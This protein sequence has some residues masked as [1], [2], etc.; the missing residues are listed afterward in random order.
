LEAVAADHRRRRYQLP[1]YRKGR[2]AL[3]GAPRVAALIEE[4]ELASSKGETE[5]AKAGKQPGAAGLGHHGSHIT[6]AH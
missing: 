1:D 4:S 3:D 5:Y 2:S 6:V